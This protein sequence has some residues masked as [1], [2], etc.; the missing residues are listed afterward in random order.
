MPACSNASH[1]VSSSSRC[2][3]SMA[4][5]SRGE[6]PKN[7]ASNSVA[8]STKPPSATYDVPGWSGSGWNSRARSQPR[9]AGN[10]E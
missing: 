4:S 8:E 5:A 1:D 6:M 7:A 10:A 2:W 9:S 3:G